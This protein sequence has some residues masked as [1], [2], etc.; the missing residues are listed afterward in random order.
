M[1]L[2]EYMVD[3]GKNIYAKVKD[4]VEEN[5]GDDDKLYKKAILTIADGRKIEFSLNDI[6]S[7]NL[8]MQ[9][10]RYYKNKCPEEGDYFCIY[11]NHSKYGFYVNTT[12]SIDEDEDI[13]YWASEIEKYP[14]DNDYSKEN[15]TMLKNY[16]DDLYKQ[17]STLRYD[18]SA[19]HNPDNR[20][21][22]GRE[23]Y[24]KESVNNALAEERKTNPLAKVIPS[25]QK[26]VYYWANIINGKDAGKFKRSQK[27][28]NSPIDTIAFINELSRLAM[29]E[30]KSGKEASISS[31]DWPGLI[32]SNAMDAAKIDTSRAPKFLLMEVGI[33]SIVVRDGTT[34]GYR[35]I[36]D[37]S[38]EEKNIKSPSIFTESF[39]S[40]IMVNVHEIEGEKVKNT[41][42]CSKEMAQKILTKKGD[43]YIFDFN[44]LIPIPDGFNSDIPCGNIENVAIVEYL[45]FLQNHNPEEYKRIIEVFSSIPETYIDLDPSSTADTTYIDL[46]GLGKQYVNNILVSGC[47]T[48]D[49]WNKKHW[50]V[51]NNAFDVIVNF[52]DDTDSCYITFS[53]D[54]RPPIGIMQACSRLRGAN[55]NFIWKAFFYSEDIEYDYNIVDG[56]IVEEPTDSLKR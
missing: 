28:F 19:T 17:M 52:E 4:F 26:A 39:D 5:K 2:Q 45:K 25:V 13:D 23:E 38:P 10:H 56:V 46:I 8:V 12:I 15:E 47:A 44:T 42:V 49:E 40:D 20:K 22:A 6:E 24:I 14:Y 34:E 50:S 27:L 11:E 33:N 7:P 9:N 43:N 1:D 36:L 37:I 21:R 48:W 32:L 51:K 29:E 16:L 35:E 54:T 41:I 30:L 31:E 53:T 3:I 55:D 18:K